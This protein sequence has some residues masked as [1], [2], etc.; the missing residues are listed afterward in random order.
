MM[1]CLKKSKLA[2]LIVQLW[3]T[4]GKTKKCKFLNYQMGPLLKVLSKL[5]DKSGNKFRPIVYYSMASSQAPSRANVPL[6]CFTSRIHVVV[7][8]P[9]MFKKKNSA[10]CIIAQSFFAQCGVKIPMFLLL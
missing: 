2:L 6:S 8:M 9:Q 10:L 4:F 3:S 7:Q 5:A 1:H